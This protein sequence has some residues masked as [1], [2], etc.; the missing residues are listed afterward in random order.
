[1]DTLKDVSVICLVTTGGAF[2]VVRSMCQPFKAGWYLSDFLVTKRSRNHISPSHDHEVFVYLARF[3]PPCRQLLRSRSR[4]RQRRG[5]K[6]QEYTC[7]VNIVMDP[8]EYIEHVLAR[9]VTIE[10][11]HF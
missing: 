9:V 4:S 3:T 7:T 6:W 5:C 8:Q 10:T 2:H 1:M 11:D